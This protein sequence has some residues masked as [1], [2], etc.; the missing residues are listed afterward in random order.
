[1]TIRVHVSH[2]LSI[3]DA[4]RVERSRRS[5]EHGGRLL[6]FSGGSALRPL[7]RALKEYT[8]NSIHLVTPFDS[9]GSSAVIR[10]AFRVLS[11]GDIRNRLVALADESVLG[12]PQLYRLFGHR[13]AKHGEPAALRDEMLAMIAREHPLIAGVP[14]P[15]RQTLASQ[16]GIFIDRAPRDFDLSGA[17][18]GNLL[19]IG[20]YF[21][22]GV[23]IDAAIFVLSKLLEVRG[24]VWPTVDADCHLA[25]RLADGST[26]VG[27]HLITGK[28]VPALGQRI[29]DFSL[30]DD[31]SD[32]HP[33][34]VAISEKVR[35]LIERSAEL[36]CYSYG[37]FYSSMLANLLPAGVGRAVARADCLKV[38]VPNLGDDP[39][40][41][42]LSLFELV[43]HILTYL[44]KDA[45]ADV[46]VERL[47]NL[48]LLD[49]RWL[50][51][52]T[53]EALPRLHALGIQ[54]AM[55]DF[56]QQELPRVEP[57]RLAQILISLV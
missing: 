52:G 27:Q 7:S 25:V 39:E 9:G 44:R 32:P 46:P 16:L 23:N 48:V 40:Q 57:Q 30:V 56:T 20:A 43:E 36:I 50:P 12:N 35:Q 6:F 34:E 47:L 2:G 10:R 55:L 15:M 21:S 51:A 29:T 22:Y 4:L 3:P 38:Y 17:N 41:A 13:L 26:V 19:L 5:P 18:I 24:M 1:M 45:G 33:V 42:G 49:P 31:L 53:E 54:T 14:E 28:E 8:H 37:S 11:V